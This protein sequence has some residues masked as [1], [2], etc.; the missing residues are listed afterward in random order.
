MKIG[1]VSQTIIIA[2]L[3]GTVA[4]LISW[5]LVG[6][7]LA[8]NVYRDAQEK[9]G[10]VADVLG[11]YFDIGASAA[12]SLSG[13]PGISNDSGFLSE[14]SMNAAIDRYENAFGVSVIY[15]LD[16][17]G[18]VIATSNRDAN[19][20]FMG[21]DFSFRSYVQDALSGSPSLYFA[22]GTVSNERGIYSSYPIRSGGRIIGVIAVKQN[23]AIIEPILQPHHPILIVSPEGVIF[24]SSDTNLTMT[25]LS[26]LSSTLQDAVKASR[27]FGAEDIAY[28][29]ITLGSAWGNPSLRI[30]DDEY[31]YIESEL[32]LLGWRLIAGVATDTILLW[33]LEAMVVIVLVTLLG[34]LLALVMQTSVLQRKQVRSGI[35]FDKLFS[36][37]V[38]GQAIVDER[39]RF[40]K[41]NDALLTMTGLS[42]EA[43]LSPQS[44]T[45]AALFGAQHTGDLL[46]HCEEDNVHEHQ[47]VRN[48]LPAWLLVAFVPLEPAPSESFGLIQMR[49]VTVER[50]Q[51]EAVAQKS[52]EIEKVNQMLL[53]REDKLHELLRRQKQPGS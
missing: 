6:A 47:I 24:L 51:R 9:Q 11:Y 40:T 4:T 49:D 43:A 22:R 28:S 52:A 20:S 15:V 41:V 32:P 39:G 13:S 2:L 26:P 38:L 1:S 37:P 53:A 18:I 36:S 42:R 3:I 31:L 35:L 45:L 27:Q 16:H 8:G 34:A 14:E 19:D 33:R 25:S 48:G 5:P 23:A 50:Q 17:N 46:V 7:K 10:H 30:G 21:K 12:R 29:G 44:G